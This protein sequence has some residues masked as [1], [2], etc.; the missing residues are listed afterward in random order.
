MNARDE[1]AWAEARLSRWREHRD[2]EA[3][4]ELLKWQRDR[5]CAIAWRMLRRK[6]AAEDAVQQACLKLLTRTRG[7]EDVEAFRVAVYRAVVQETLNLAA[8]DRARRKREQYA[9]EGATTARETTDAPERVEALRAVREELAALPE[10]DRAAVVLCAQEGLPVSAA[11]RVL[12]LP[13]ESVRD[14]L[15]RALSR[16]RAKLE[17]RGMKASLAA[18][19]LLLQQDRAPAAGKA[20][21]AALDAALPGASCAGIGAQGAAG[22]APASLL[23]Q[24]GLAAKAGAWPVALGASG[25]VVAGLVAALALLPV[26]R[27]SGTNE[28]AQLN[29]QV[30]E[31]QSNDN[32]TRAGE[33]PAQVKE[34]LAMK[35]SLRKTVAATTLALVLSA[36]LARAQEAEAAA[37]AAEEKA[38]KEEALELEKVLRREVTFEFVETPAGEAL[39]FLQSLTKQNL[40]VDPNLL[41]AGSVI[42]LKLQDVTLKHALDRIAE[43]MKGKV[44]FVDGACYVGRGEPAAQDA[45]PPLA[46]GE[47][48]KRKA[49]FDLVDTPLNEAG[50]F[51]GSFARVPVNL[52]R[53]LEAVWV[54][55]RANDMELGRA[56]R[57]IA[58]LSG[59]KLAFGENDIRFVKPD[60]MP[61][62]AHDF[63]GGGFTGGGAVAP[64]AMPAPPQ[65]PSAPQPAPGEPDK[66]GF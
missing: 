41:A 29:V 5:A 52:D 23:A 35:L 17:R 51:I 2:R 19:A 3:L 62:A 65:V 45:R 57:W 37:Q 10:T 32:S 63:T 64:A 58:R 38:A 6:E 7:F 12:D 18:L 48:L 54:S 40:V 53:G 50:E 21:C 1:M 49:S 56:L 42:T 16:L 8:S 39:A 36:P 47:K 46:I 55:L 15:A 33:S 44:L 26:G 27:P 30:N 28:S 34:L 61:E 22:M 13:R 20:L 9:M 60:A 25:L 43:Q 31:A 59:T 11:A 66:Q 24:A 14:R 4:G